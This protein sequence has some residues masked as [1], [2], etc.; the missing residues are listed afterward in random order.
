MPRTSRLLLVP[1]TLIISTLLS[2]RLPARSPGGGSRSPVGAGDAHF[3]PAG[4]ARILYTGRID[5]SN[6]LEPRFWAPGVYIR[7]RFEGPGCAVYLKDQVLYGNNHN[8]VEVAL[9]GEQPYRVQMKGKSDTLNVAVGQNQA[10]QKAGPHTL[11]ICKDTESGIGYLAF[12]GLRCE[13]LLS[14]PPVP[15][16]KI[17]FIGNSITCGTGSDQSVVACDQGQWYDQ[18]NAYLSYG[19][20]TA[21]LLDADW[22]LSSV[23]GIGLIHSCCNMT[24]TMP[25]VFDKVNM[26]DD[27]ISW[28][29]RNY[30]PDVVTV[31]LGQND[32]VQDSTVFCGA[33]VTFLHTLRA[34][35]PGADIICLTSPMAV[36]ALKAVMCRYLGGVVAEMH[37]E[38]D[39]KI[40]DYFFSGWYHHGCGGHPDLEEHKAIAG[41]LSARIKEITGW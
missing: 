1:I 24:V 16:R 30:R 29:F 25:Q 19:P 21:R 23:S 9:D 33:Y 10:G 28:D 32:G 6:P 11:T 5:F 14:P 15:H 13:D 26:R 18:H 31:C 8:Y 7:I 17:E 12:C 39:Q 36:P 3:Y 20:T 35:Y 38:G 4:D 34:H 2:A 41:E 27:S 37:R 40:F 22:C